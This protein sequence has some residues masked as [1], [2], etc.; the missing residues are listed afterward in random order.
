MT[1][2]NTIPRSDEND[3]TIDAEYMNRWLGDNAQIQS[4]SPKTLYDIQTLIEYYRDIIVPGTKVSISFPIG[5]DD[6]GPRASVADGKVIIPFHMLKEGRVDETIG[7][8]IHE[9]HHI[10]LS[11]SERFTAALTFKI[12]R[13]MME[14][15]DCGGMTM[16]ERLFSDSS[17]TAE[18]ILDGKGGTKD[19]MFL[20]ES[21]EDLM[22]LLNAVE[23]IR[24]D[25]NTPPNLRKY[26]DKIDEQAGAR[27]R[28]ARDN[29]AFS[30]D[31][32]DLTAIGFM[33]LAHH[34]GLCEFDFVKERYGDTDAIING[35]PHKYP[36][37]VFGT[38]KDEIAS[39]IL[40]LY[41]KHC[42]KPKPVDDGS[43]P[44]DEGDP[45]D[46]DAYFGGKVGS[47][48]GDSVEA[49]FTTA[50]N[51]S[52]DEEKQEDEDEALKDADK[53]IKSIGI[54]PNPVVTAESCNT[55]SDVEIDLSGKEDIL[56]EWKATPPS[57][58]K[59]LRDQIADEEKTVSITP[60]ME[61]QIK[62]YKNVRVTTTTEHFNED[63][64]VF[65]SVL[66][67]TVNN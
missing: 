9:L 16:A 25:A 32:R 35:D 45:L 18:R 15:I 58:A 31:E 4:L 13:H 2:P 5:S 60:Q 43:N 12:L 46:L 28:E 54:P 17:V 49:Q 41:Y 22:F 61:T 48:L 29:G 6:G 56:Y 20:R 3:I 57:T 8:M 27:I 44:G 14:Q 19:I 36:I 51:N 42:G 47:S 39:H 67:D 7:A 65:D 10:K 53:G 66:F 11:A 52:Q 50:K 63:M 62:S 55:K 24:I 59:E 23:D 21:I 38:F 30:E 34:K 40:Q 26:I 64:V 1:S 33:I 37:D